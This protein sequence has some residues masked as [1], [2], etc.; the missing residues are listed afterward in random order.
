MLRE[1]VVSTPGEDGEARD[2]PAPQTLSI[3][4]G[5]G[6][7]KQIQTQS[8]ENRRW[9]EAQRAEVLACPF[10]GSGA[11]KPTFQT[12]THS[13]KQMRSSSLKPGRFSR[14]AAAVPL[15]SVERSSPRYLPASLGVTAAIS[16]LEQVRCHF[17]GTVL[18]AHQPEKK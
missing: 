9:L 6:K 14:E 4:A 17:S 16:C 10:A 1:F 15:P 5:I 2:E 11:E 8:R 3:Y 13:P 12:Q 18:W 7:H